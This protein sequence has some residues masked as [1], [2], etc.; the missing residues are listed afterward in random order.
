MPSSG[1]RS[2]CYRPMPSKV[3]FPELVGP[4]K[5]LQY[6]TFYSAYCI[7]YRTV[8]INRLFIGKKRF[9][10]GCIM[11]GKHKRLNS[12]A[13]LFVPFKVSLD[14]QS[15]NFKFEKQKHYYATL[16]SQKLYNS[17]NR[18]DLPI[19]NQINQLNSIQGQGQELWIMNQNHLLLLKYMTGVFS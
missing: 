18:I 2:P 3:F 10:F 16:N 13:K 6:S 8:N 12:G 7:V 17:I 14:W 4:L 5:K 19:L 11:L 1:V 9:T 15:F